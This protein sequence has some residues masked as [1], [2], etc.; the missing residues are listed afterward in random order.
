MT[1]RAA[2]TSVFFINGA[3]VGTWVAHIPYVQDR[4]GVSKATIGVALLCMA[5]GALVSMPITGQILHRRPSARV[6]RV[7]ALVYC[8][9]GP[10]PVIAPS[11]A[12]LC[13]LLVVFGAFNGAMDV[14]MNAHGVAV[15]RELGKPIMSSLH[16]GWSF[17]GF[18]AA[19]AASLATAAGV[20]ARAE[21]AATTVVLWLAALVV[22]ARLGSASTHD[23]EAAAGFALPSRGVLLLGALCVIA[24][25]VE[26]SMNDW[27][28]IYLR[29]NLGAGAA[30]AS[31]GFAGFS[32]GMALCRVGGD[33][34]NERIGPKALLRGGMLMVAASLGAL[35]LIAEPVPAVIGFTL[36][37]LGVANGVPVIF[38]AAGRVPPSGPSLSAVFTIGYSGFLAGPPLLGVL[39]D[40]IGLP[41]TLGLVCVAALVVAALAGV[42]LG[43][44]DR[45]AARAAVATP[46]PG[47]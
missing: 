43:A 5:L 22:T 7:A 6:V 39:A 34:V 45:A 14:S 30:A 40:A 16:A 35:L 37:G 15:E 27:S 32:L 47:R 13:A 41:T 36:V 20:E 18:F 29:H 44:G 10:L 4:L 2:T 26:G 31:L 21:T 3:M 23:E 19:G 38:S 25:V 46:A 11:P 42:A 8:L 9:L 28:G 1:P 17:G 24:M 12:A 33:K